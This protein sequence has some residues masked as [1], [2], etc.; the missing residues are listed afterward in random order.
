[1]QISNDL[2]GVEGVK[3]DDLVID[4]TDR[5][6]RT[7]RA[8]K[9]GIPHFRVGGIENR[10]MAPIH[11]RSRSR[12]QPCRP[13]QGRGPEPK[14]GGEA[15]LEDVPACDLTIYTLLIASTCVHVAPPGAASPDNA[16]M[17]T[18]HNAM[19]QEGVKR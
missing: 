5:H 1:G 10:Q 6:Q 7:D 4:G 17:T 9:V 8:C 14:T 11:G 2:L 12:T 15:S 19:R 16:L 18:A 3:L 13:H